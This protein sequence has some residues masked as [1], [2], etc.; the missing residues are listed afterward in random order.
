MR[1]SI[2]KGQ[3]F[4]FSQ[5]G[6]RGFFYPSEK[7]SNILHDTIGIRLSWVGSSNKKAIAVPESAVLQSGS[8]EK[9]IAIWI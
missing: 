4:S 5:E 3:P 6:H 2:K 8:E 9:K 1:V 7:S